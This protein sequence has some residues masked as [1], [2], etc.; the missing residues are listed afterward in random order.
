MLLTR[1]TTLRPDGPHGQ[2]FS[3]GTATLLNQVQQRPKE[4]RKDTELWVF[5]GTQ[6]ETSQTHLLLPTSQQLDTSK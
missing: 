5:S 3:T 4:P 2:T 1:Q 6:K